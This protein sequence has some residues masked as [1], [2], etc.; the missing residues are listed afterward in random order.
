MIYIIKGHCYVT[1]ESYQEAYPTK[2]EMI[3]GLRK[4]EQT[5][6]ELV[7]SLEMLKKSDQ[8]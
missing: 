4:I 5:Q 7:K 8:N 2:M 6:S 1:N 3:E